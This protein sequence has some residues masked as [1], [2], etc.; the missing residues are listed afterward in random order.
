M[1]T[2]IQA[3]NYNVGKGPSSVAI[4][5]S[6][7]G[8]YLI[9]TSN[10]DDNKISVHR[11]TPTG[12]FVEAPNSPYPVGTKPYS[13]AIGDVNGDGYLDIVVA[14]SGSN[15]VS[16][17]L[18]NDAGTFAP[19]PNSPYTVGT[20][21]YSVAIG[22]VNGDGYPDIVVANHDSNTVSVLLGNAAKTFAK[23]PN[24]P[25]P[26][27]TK[28][29]SVAIGD[30]NGDG[31]M[32][33]VVANSGSDSVLVYLGN[34]TGTLAQAPNSPYPVGKNPRSVALGD[35]NKDGKLAIFVA[36]YGSNS[37]SVL[38]GNSDR[39]FSQAPN[40]PYSVD[41][42]PSS[43]A[44]ADL[45]KDG[46]LDMVTANEVDNTVSVL[47]NFEGTLFSAPNFP[48]SSGKNPVSVVLEDADKD[49]NLDIIIANKGSNLFSIIYGTID[50]PFSQS[51][52]KFMAQQLSQPM[53]KI[54]YLKQEVKGL[55]Q[56][57]KGLK[58]EAKGLKQEA[59]G[60]KQEVKGL[61]Q[62]AKGLKQKL[63]IRDEELERKLV[64]RDEEFNI[65]H[66]ERVRVENLKA[67]EAKIQECVE[68]LFEKAEG[69]N[70]CSSR[71]NH[72][73]QDSSE[74][75]KENEQMTKQ[76][77]AQLDQIT[78]YPFIMLGSIIVGVNLGHTMFNKAVDGVT[79]G[80]LFGAAV[81]VLHNYG[82]M[83][84]YVTKVNSI[85]DYAI[86]LNNNITDYVTQ[87][88]GDAKTEEL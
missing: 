14:N 1:H 76:L 37:V 88:I 65:T 17:Y 59:K 42:S 78:L 72:N 43:I 34:D 33:I 25:Y 22:D 47:I 82:N 18:G 10:H 80:A 26:V 68:A 39:T 38:L 73:L 56:E 2:N 64:I 19:A 12:K 48:Y 13:V 29:Y 60:L 30:V 4:A 44:I 40:S 77:K 46:Y 81:C 54:K 55:K 66:L 52:G 8:G 86:K 61:E 67:T 27:G 15:T 84:D 57:V 85:T 32:D 58:Q 7:K 62:E 20:K 21:P 23:A 87:L 71:N 3:V 6:N 45:N 9:V 35:I 28:P 49:G 75:Q 70:N 69:F 31:F 74:P 83:T 79:I 16:V 63:V 50:G 5:D 11:S 36:N 51:M 53:E 41:K 24:S